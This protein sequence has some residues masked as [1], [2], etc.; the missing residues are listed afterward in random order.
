MPFSSGKGEKILE[1]FFAVFEY[2][3]STAVPSLKYVFPLAVGFFPFP[4]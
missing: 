3:F 2:G 4:L 1:L